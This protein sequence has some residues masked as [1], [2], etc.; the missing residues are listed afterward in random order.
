MSK[1]S[2]YDITILKNKAEYNKQK[3]SIMNFKRKDKKKIKRNEM[4]SFVDEILKSYRKKHQDGIIEVSIKYPNRWYSADATYI[5]DDINYF[6]LNE[7]DEFDDDPEEYAEFRVYFIPIVKKSQGGADINNDCLINCIKKVIQSHKN[8]IDAIEIKQLLGLQRNDKISINQLSKVEEYIKRK[9]KMEYGFYVSGDFQYTTKLQTLKQIHLILS[10]EHYTLDKTQYFKR[11]HAST[12]D[13]KI[14]MYEYDNDDYSCFD[15]NE[16]YYITKEDY[17]H[18]YGNPITSE[19]ILVDKNFRMDV[20]KNKLCLEDAYHEYIEM[21]DIIKE[22]TN[23]YIN[24]YRC[25]SVKHMALNL[26]FDKVK[27]VFPDEISNIEAEY[28]HDGSFGALTYWQKYEGVVYSY[29]RNSQYPYLMS[30]NYNKFPIK[31]GEFKFIKTIDNEPSYGI[32][33]CKITNPK[34]ISTKFFRFNHRNYY[35]HLDIMTAKS[36]GLNIELIHDDQANFLYYADDKLLNGA[37]LFGHYVNDL[38]K[39]KLD[40]IKGAKDI[41]NILWGAL[42]E[43]NIHKRNITF[44]EEIELKDYKILSMNGG[45]SNINFRLLPTRTKM[46]KTNWAR[47]KPFI[48]GYGRYSFYLHCHQ[49]EDLVIR[50]NTDGIYFNDKPQDLHDKSTDPKYNNKMGF[51]KYEGDKTINLTGLNKGLK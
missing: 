29:D 23:G 19:Y 22:K 15:G 2:K 17:N 47:I 32:Y 50:I 3:M 33:R 28:I 18:I 30:R 37:F 9:T 27:S 39:L 36:Y 25:G 13:K 51:F 10:K 5:K 31:E 26:F 21:A 8:E 1:T 42:S 45:E 12:E 40:K 48:L 14:L 24:F 41:L 49:Y 16:N 35:T 11:K 7:Y 4:I 44:D 20:K 46:F 43:M 38:Y 6:S 34:S